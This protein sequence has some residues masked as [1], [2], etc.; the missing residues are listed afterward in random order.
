MT[1]KMTPY[2]AIKAARKKFDSDVAFAKAL[3]TSHQQVGYMLKTA[4]MA[5]PNFVIPIESATG[6]SR[7]DL[8]PDLHPR[9]VI[10]PKKR[11]AGRGHHAG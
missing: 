10:A 4:K 1:K 5:T 9:P 6:I 7:H 3:G 11:A 8:R 2:T